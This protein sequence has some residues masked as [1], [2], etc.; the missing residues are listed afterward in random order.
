MPVVQVGLLDQSPEGSQS[1]RLK[2]GIP[3]GDSFDTYPDFFP[4]TDN[5]IY[6]SKRLKPVSAGLVKLA[7][8]IVSCCNV[9]VVDEVETLA[10][11]E[12]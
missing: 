2:M 6:V 9:L 3:A 1:S 11:E 7:G 8:V 5:R 10:L 4:R 12:S